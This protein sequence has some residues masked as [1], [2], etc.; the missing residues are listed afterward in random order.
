MCLRVGKSLIM[1]AI[2]HCCA[3]RHLPQHICGWAR[4]VLPC[5]AIAANIY[6]CLS[7]MSLFG[8][9]YARVEAVAKLRCTSVNGHLN[10]E[11]S[12][13]VNLVSAGLPPE[14]V[15]VLVFLTQC[16]FR[17][18]FTRAAVDAV[19]LFAGQ[20]SVTRALRRH[21]WSLHACVRDW[22]A[23]TCAITQSSHGIGHGV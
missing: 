16:H 12:W 19:E 20:R 11:V 7:L 17:G 4:H 13:A 8:C 22:F 18:A 14:F 15:L 23:T 5:T 6:S 10:S 21:A 2:R 9:L 1:F 3:L